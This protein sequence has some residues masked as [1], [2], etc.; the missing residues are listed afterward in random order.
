MDFTHVP[1]HPLLFFTRSAVSFIRS[2]LFSQGMCDAFP[3]FSALAQLLDELFPFPFGLCLFLPLLFLYSPEKPR[4]EVRKGDE[5][6]QDCRKR[7]KGQIPRGIL[8][9]I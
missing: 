7:G 6:V 3:G 1:I 8:L 9:L 5:K 4:T 2:G